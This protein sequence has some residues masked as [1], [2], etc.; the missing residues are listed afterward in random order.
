[1]AGS[2]RCPISGSCRSRSRRRRHYGVGSWSTAA[3]RARLHRRLVG[4][5]N[6]AS[7][8]TSLGESAGGRC[9]D[10]GFSPFLPMCIAS[11]T[12]HWK[13]AAPRTDTATDVSDQWSAAASRKGTDWQRGSGESRTLRRSIP[14]TV[15]AL[16]LD[17][18]SKPA[19]AFA[20]K[21]TSRI[22][23]MNRHC[24]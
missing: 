19:N 12:T 8:T 21:E 20:C 14:T 7:Q 23:S 17:G 2:S 11:R 15:F 13:A 4:N 22:T 9:G 6:G 16:G 18:R 1:M 24:G 3:P 10:G 5:R